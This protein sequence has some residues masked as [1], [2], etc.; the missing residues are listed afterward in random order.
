MFSGYYLKCSRINCIGGEIITTQKAGEA[1]SPGLS[2][3]L[4]DISLLDYVNSDISSDIGFCVTES[5]YNVQAGSSNRFSSGAA[6]E[7]QSPFSQN[8][9]LIQGQYEPATT[10]QNSKLNEIDL[11]RFEGGFEVS[12]ETNIRYQK[13]ANIDAKNGNKHHTISQICH[14]L[15]G[16]MKI[17]RNGDSFTNNESS[18]SLSSNKKYSY[19]EISKSQETSKKSLSDRKT[20]GI[21]RLI[22]KK[23]IDSDAVI[24]LETYKSDLLCSPRKKF[25]KRSGKAMSDIQSFEKHVYQNKSFDKTQQNLF[26]KFQQSASANSVTSVFDLFHYETRVRP[27]TDLATDSNNDR[28]DSSSIESGSTGLISYYTEDH[29]EWNLRNSGSS[30]N[31]NEIRRGI[32]N[33]SPDLLVNESRISGHPEI[34]SVFEDTAD[35]YDNCTDELFIDNQSTSSSAFSFEE[36]GSS[37]AYRR[38]NNYSKPS[39]RH[40]CKD[41]GDNNDDSMLSHFFGIFRSNTDGH[42]QKASRLKSL[43]KGISEDSMGRS[44]TLR[45][46]ERESSKLVKTKKDLRL[47]RGPESEI[48]RTVRKRFE[49]GL[50]SPLPEMVL[51]YSRSMRNM[52]YNLKMSHAVPIREKQGT[53]N[54]L[55]SNRTVK[56]RVEDIAVMLFGSS[57]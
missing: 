40:N 3:D 16:K 39:R 14:K 25:F 49:G 48:V 46:H 53:L 42:I 2:E 19:V 28:H 13:S 7:L 37:A 35:F 54:S 23:N 41:D 24:A 4:R 21:F 52:V 55:K 44:L 33:E 57:R 45:Y 20:K 47:R 38:I 18:T 17:L 51:R 8:Q 43:I 5:S 6:D 50:V 36:I 9:V 56:S 10:I 22:S 27:D 29:V 30:D 32:F 12:K 11:H 15:A 31:G 34:L 26:A 1:D